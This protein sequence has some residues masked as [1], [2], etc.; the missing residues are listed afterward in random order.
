MH[1]NLRFFIFRI[2]ILR[3][4]LASL[5]LSFPTFIHA[6]NSIWMAPF[7]FFSGC[8]TAL[9]KIA[10]GMERLA[11]AN[12]RIPDEMKLKLVRTLDDAGIYRRGGRLLVVR[13]TD[14]HGDEAQM[15]EI[16]GEEL[17]ETNAIERRGGFY[18]IRSRRDRSE[19][20]T[21]LNESLQKVLVLDSHSDEGGI[22]QMD[23]PDGSG[24]VFY[25]GNRFAILRKNEH[26]ALHHLA[27]QNGGY[28]L[29][30]ERIGNSIENISF[31]EPDANR[32]LRL[33]QIVVKNWALEPKT[34]WYFDPSLGTLASKD[35]SLG[36]PRDSASVRRLESRSE[37]KFRG[38][39]LRL[40]SRQDQETTE[41]LG[42]V[43]GLVPLVSLGFSIHEP[44][45]PTPQPPR[46]VPVNSPERQVDDYLVLGDHPGLGIARWQ[47]PRG[48]GIAHLHNFTPTDVGQKSTL[49]NFELNPHLPSDTQK[50]RAKEVQLEVDDPFLTI[51]S[52]ETQGHKAMFVFPKHPSPDKP[53]SIRKGRLDYREDERGITVLHEDFEP[54]L[55]MKPIDSAP[56]YKPLLGYQYDV[57]IGK[58][59]VAEIVREE[60]P[61]LQSFHLRTS[62][63]V[64]RFFKEHPLFPRS[65]ATKDLLFA[66]LE[67]GDGKDGEMVMLI[68]LQSRQTAIIPNLKK[69]VEFKHDNLSMPKETS[70]DASFS[71]DTFVLLGEDPQD[72]SKTVYTVWNRQS[73]R[74]YPNFSGQEPHY[75][76]RAV[77]KSRSNEERDQDNKNSE[78]S[79]SALGRIPVPL[80][81]LDLS[82]EKPYAL[83]RIDSKTQPEGPSELSLWL[84]VRPN[85]SQPIK[86]VMGLRP[87]KIEAEVPEEHHETY[88]LYGAEGSSVATAE[89][90]DH[91]ALLE[92]ES[93]T[94]SVVITLSRNKRNYFD[95]ST[96]N[97]HVV[98]GKP[99]SARYLS[100]KA[101][102][103]RGTWILKSTVGRLGVSHMAEVTL[104]DAGNTGFV[105]PHI[106]RYE[107]NDVFVSATSAFG[108]FPPGIL[109]EDRKSGDFRFLRLS[110]EPPQ[111]KSEGGGDILNFLAF[112]M[113]LDKPPKDSKIVNQ[114]PIEK[115]ERFEDLLLIRTRGGP[116]TGPMTYIYCLREKKVIFAVP[117]YVK[118]LK[119]GD[120]LLFVGQAS[121]RNQ[122][123]VAQVRASNYQYVN[124][125]DLG[126]VE[127]DLD[128]PSGA[129]EYQE[130]QKRI[131]FR[132]RGGITRIFDLN[133]FH[134][135]GLIPSDVRSQLR[136]IEKESV[137]LLNE[138]I[139]SNPPHKTYGRDKTLAKMRD[140]LPFKFN[141]SKHHTLL[142]GDRGVGSTQ[143]MNQFIN[144][145]LSG[146]GIDDLGFHPVFLRLDATRILGAGATEY[147][148]VLSQKM[149]AIR[150]AAKALAPKG[151]RLVVLVDG[152]ERLSANNEG[153]GHDRGYD[154]S[155][156]LYFQ[157]GKLMEDNVIDVI[158]ATTPQ[159]AATLVRRHPTLMTQFGA[160]IEVPSMN[161]A[162]TEEALK[163]YLGDNHIDLSH[164]P[165]HALTSMLSYLENWSPNRSLPAI[166]FEVMD[167]VIANKGKQFTYKDLIHGVAKKTGI[168]DVLVDKEKLPQV[169]ADLDAFIEAR[170]QGQPDARKAMVNAVMAFAY[171]TGRADLPIGRLLFPGPT[172]VGKTET[173]RAVCEFLFGSQKPLLRIEGGSYSAPQS[174]DQL[175]NLRNTI[176]RH[177]EQYPFNIILL[178]EFEKMH[179][180][181]RD[182]ILS[183]ADGGLTNEKGRSVRSNLSLLVATTNA[184]SSEIQAA[185]RRIGFAGAETSQGE[186]NATVMRALATEFKPEQLGRFAVVVP[187][188]QLSPEMAQSIVRN[189]LVGNSA[190][191][192]ES[193]SQRF[194]KLGIDLEFTDEL[195]AH[196]AKHL[197]KPGLGGRGLANS[198]EES[199][200]SNYL[201]PL[202][203]KGELQS[204]KKYRIGL[205]QAGYTMEVIEN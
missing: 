75:I 116:L 135:I 175:E 82:L 169:A 204:G 40:E 177:M 159:G 55:T 193:I 47:S 200:V 163:G 178:D 180:D 78:S 15:V 131:L 192:T 65:D 108:K 94:Q 172:G 88:E 24:T 166:A 96:Q 130:A 134:F 107:D 123:V 51:L 168:P 25:V 58:A 92:G 12:D 3:C 170:V 114:E 39:H 93:G 145:Y 64:K 26:R 22:K 125:Y 119:V 52:L 6:K 71:A 183:L 128:N 157:L 1:G 162:E 117:N 205:G 109:V 146:D 9:A 89:S 69:V 141:G 23:L 19:F 17:A 43:R 155:R 101:D 33:M 79:N 188:N 10:A 50:N 120:Y 127:L 91:L 70:L 136:E 164:L 156:E 185:S 118:T 111:N 63:R 21:I 37:G 137:V 202:H 140:A 34:Y 149:N 84:P 32:P 62:F 104:G 189:Y 152:L 29:G 48:L 27:E 174:A 171:G 102:R 154:P 81:S 7:S 31:L 86:G 115:I 103:D 158:G 142:V 201:T 113:G 129:A 59:S 190:V 41:L 110:F 124:H 44:G 194:K 46:F 28:I 165:A 100:N 184:G 106:K 198:I 4:A 68:D 187:F 76:S 133:Q 35:P 5:F 160:R 18:L 147:V 182:I 173:V 13:A 77:V 49:R 150:T 199:I 126:K 99:V 90:L 42:E 181:A 98:L 11:K 72:S 56:E 132:L 20:L 54:S 95:G 61:H 87:W 196:M 105:D 179:R 139:F 167:D 8:S 203:I 97:V 138:E 53:F 195:I 186:I 112:L 191:K 83:I 67:G 2:W 176:I 30:T 161:L 74:F 197:I 151:Y 85:D 16:N 153:E 36:D 143:L 144:S 148:N 14:L 45:A 80:S 66:E 121:H 57:L 38:R 73:H 60:G 122:T